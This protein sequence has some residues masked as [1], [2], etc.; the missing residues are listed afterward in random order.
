MKYLLYLMFGVG[1]MYNYE[2]NEHTSTELYAYLAVML[3]YGLL[4]DEVFTL[5]KKLKEINNGL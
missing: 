3:S 1:F 4:L 5:K 2:G